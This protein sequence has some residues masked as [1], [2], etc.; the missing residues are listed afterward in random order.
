MSFDKWHDKT[1]HPL[2]GR[3]HL[4]WEKKAWNAA[5]EEV[6]KLTINSSTRKDANVNLS[7]KMLKLKVE[8]NE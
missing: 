5:I 7:N 4:I 6:L 3:E 2:L 8:V 1:Y